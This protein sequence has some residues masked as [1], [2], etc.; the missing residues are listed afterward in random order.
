M[1][2]LILELFENIPNIANLKFL[3]FFHFRLKE[4]RRQFYQKI[5]T[6]YSE[7]TI[8]KTC[9]NILSKN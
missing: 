2:L 3:N 1:N 9:C 5:V 8:K 4:P 7:I 6:T